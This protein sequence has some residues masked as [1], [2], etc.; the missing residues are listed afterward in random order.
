[1]AKAWLQPMVVLTPVSRWT[2]TCLLYATGTWLPAGSYGGSRCGRMISGH[3]LFPPTGKPWLLQT[4][5][6]SSCGNLQAARNADD[7]PDTVIGFGPWHSPRTGDFWPQDV[8]ITQRL[9]GT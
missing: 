6:P 8:R 1:M 2:L 9:S 3:W 5:T 7:L 4:M